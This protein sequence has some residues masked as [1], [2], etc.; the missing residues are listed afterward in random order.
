MFLTLTGA[1]HPDGILNPKYNGFTDLAAVAFFDAYL[2]RRPE[3]DAMPAAIEASGVGTSA[4]RSEQ[5]ECGVR[6]TGFIGS[7]I[8]AALRF[9]PPVPIDR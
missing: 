1:N 6:Y 8:M 9:R 2:A 4:Q 7:R 3:R 5:G